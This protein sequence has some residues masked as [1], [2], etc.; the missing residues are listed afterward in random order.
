MPS[1]ILLLGTFQMCVVAATPSVSPSPPSTT[2]STPS[3]DVTYSSSRLHELGSRSQHLLRH[4]MMH[5]CGVKETSNMKKKLLRNTDVT[6]NDGS[7]AG[8]FIRRARGSQKW[9]VFLEGGW[10]CFDHVSCSERSRVMPEYM[11]SRYW[12]KFRSGSG[13]LSWDP[14]ENPYYFHSNVVYVPYCSSDSWS[15]TRNKTSAMD[16][17]FMGSLI[18]DEVFDELL[19]KG[20]KQAKTVILAGT[21]AG[22]TGVLINIDR[23]ADLIHSKEPSIEVKGLV[24]AGW[25]LDNEPF[26]V[27]T[28]RDAFT[29]SPVAGIQRGYQVWSPKLPEACTA[30]HPT[31]VWRC[32]FGHRVF[33]TIKSPVYVIQNLYDA[34]Q[35][36]V[37]S[38]FEE[39]PKT[40]LSADQWRYLLSLGEEVK[41]SLQNVTAVFAPACVSHEILIQ[42]EWHTVRIQ[43]TS[44]PESIY[45]WETSGTKMPS[46]QN[47]SI[48]S[49]L[50]KNDTPLAD[51]PPKGTNKRKKKK[52][53]KKN[54]KN[55]R[56][57]KLD[58]GSV[59]RNS[60]SV[61]KRCQRR[62][63]DECPWPHCNCSCPKCR[64]ET[65]TEVNNFFLKTLATVMGID[66][67]KMASSK[68]CG[69]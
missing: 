3:P 2:P 5:S 50:L 53:G 11:S 46:C 10:Y 7:P 42:P 24:D 6:C 31:E 20:M 68:L 52:K 30:Q 55:N 25:F 37:S 61:V 21:S 32:F 65:M 1:L 64:W 59:T 49:V 16:F 18:L 9:I 51:A 56:N 33:P 17:S 14:E 54:K 39:R 47:S 57:R 4:I 23:I 28:C 48:E 8:Y 40:E 12:T 62:L 43:G 34:A 35:I 29:C 44:L 45:C 26:K 67:A 22:G 63:I 41:Q 69:Y 27:K 19:K 58:R 66:P 15:G 36:K 60:R 13:I 38:V